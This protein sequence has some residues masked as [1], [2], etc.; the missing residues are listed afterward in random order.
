MA[1]IQRRR[2]RRGPRIDALRQAK[3]IVA[4][5]GAGL[6]AAVRALGQASREDALQIGRQPSHPHGKRR[7]LA[8]QDGVQ[9]SRV[10]VSTEQHLAG[11]GL[12]KDTAEN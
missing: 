10:A 3:Q 8:F 5:F 9:N 11:Q 7:R 4:E 6:V 12:V 2:T 1:I